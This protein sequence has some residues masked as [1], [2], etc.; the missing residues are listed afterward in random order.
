M[1][2]IAE[3]AGNEA[4]AKSLAPTRYVEIL[5]RDAEGRA[6]AGDMDELSE[7]LTHMGITAADAQADRAALAEVRRLEAQPPTDVSAALG[8][9]EETNQ[10]RKDE[11]ER[12]RLAMKEIS[13]KSNAAAMTMN[14]ANA[15]QRQ[16]HERLTNLHTAHPRVFG[17]KA[18]PVVKDVPVMSGSV[19]APRHESFG[20]AVRK[21]GFLGRSQSIQSNVV[22]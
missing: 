21:N 4:A 3:L 18:S 17:V 15:A 13:E 16:R 10:Q 6:T 14:S 22:G 1:S 8:S 19:Q 7:I 12:H 20:D 2:R 11:E 9:V 5:A